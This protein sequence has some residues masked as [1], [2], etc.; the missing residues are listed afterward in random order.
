MAMSGSTNAII[1]LIAMARRAGLELDLE[2]FDR[3]SNETGVIADI[4]PSGRFLME[5][6]HYAGGFPGFLRRLSPHLKRDEMT[7]SGKTL[8]EIYENA[9]IFDDE[10]IRATR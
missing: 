8:G 5:D 1:H 3:L 6:F 7:V 2:S 4:R 9:S 10:I